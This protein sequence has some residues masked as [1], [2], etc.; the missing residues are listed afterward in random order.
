MDLL[1]LTD[2]FRKLGCHIVPAN[3]KSEL[4]R[5]LLISKLMK[6]PTY[7][8]FDSDGE[9]NNTTKRIKHE[10]D[11]KIL[12]KLVDGEYQTPFPDDNVWGKGFTVWKS[13][14][15]KIVKNELGSLE[16][17]K[18]SNKV[19][20]KYDQIGGLNK[21]SLFISSV[22]YEASLE[23]NFSESL[24]KICEMILEE[25]NFVCFDCNY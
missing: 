11:N 6:I 7:L 19:N 14:I 5:P 22:L 16:W 25:D 23:Q 4:Y 3:G 9:E 10:K 17:D 2:K 13:D 1:G 18:Y 21:N 15:G 12:L 20:Q 24:R 8:I